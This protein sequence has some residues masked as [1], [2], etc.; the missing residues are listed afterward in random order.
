VRAPSPW[1]LVRGPV[2][3]E[4]RSVT[5]ELDESPVVETLVIEKG[6]LGPVPPCR[7]EIR[8]MT[9]LVGPQGTGK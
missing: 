8:P 6:S 2:S 3:C 1:E 5:R 7:L 4:S 9:V